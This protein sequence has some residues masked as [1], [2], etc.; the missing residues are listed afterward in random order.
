MPAHGISAR[1][2]GQ[3]GALDI[4]PSAGDPAPHPT[5]T[6][7]RELR[8][9]DPR[10]DAGI[11]A[12][13]GRLRGSAISRGGPNIIP[14]GSRADAHRPHTPWCLF[15][16]IRHCGLSS[17][18]PRKSTRCVVHRGARPTFMGPL[19]RAQINQT[20]NGWISATR[21]VTSAPGAD[22]PA[23]EGDFV[24]LSS[25]TGR[26]SATRDTSSPSRGRILTSTSRVR[27]PMC[28]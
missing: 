25:R 28:R 10:V 3:R 20:A 16:A 23:R 26:S 1:D 15:N 5:P 13:R 12:R 7:R 4:S 17:R 22:R 8:R 18:S 2:G 9:R 14:S 6:G 24:A 11:S 19:D 21:R 27:S